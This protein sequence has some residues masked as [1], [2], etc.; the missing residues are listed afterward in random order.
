MDAF[1]LAILLGPGLLALVV[2]HG[3]ALFFQQHGPLAWTA[4]ALAALM[5]LGLHVL[6]R[7]RH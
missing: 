6:V 5:G 2:I 1:I 7:T 4:V 3:I